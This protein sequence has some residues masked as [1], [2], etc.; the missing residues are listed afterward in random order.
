MILAEILRK[1]EPSS[2]GPPGQRH[3]ECDCQDKSH[4]AFAAARSPPEPLG[5][6]QRRRQQQNHADAADRQQR[7]ES[8][9]D[10]HN[11]TVGARERPLL[12]VDGQ[13]DE[14][15]DERSGWQGKQWKDDGPVALVVTDTEPS[16]KPSQERCQKRRAPDGEGMSTLHA[17]TVGAP[18]Q[19][20]AAPTLTA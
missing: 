10:S 17:S 14:V 3:A 16:Q 13:A 6:Q 11:E 19:L 12:P 8:S 18:A 7:R 20:A 15:A 4:G 5:T 2:S 1:Q 9:G